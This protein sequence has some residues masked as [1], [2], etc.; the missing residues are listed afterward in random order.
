M[1]KEYR[2]KEHIGKNISTLDPKDYL[3][4]NFNDISRRELELRKGF[5][6]KIDMVYNK[7]LIY[8]T[9]LKSIEINNLF[10]IKNNRDSILIE[11]A[12]EFI[13]NSN[14]IEG[15]KI[16]AEEVKK[17][18]ENGDSKYRNRNEVKEVFNS[19]KA[20]EYIQNGFKFNISSIKG[21][22]YI[23]TQDLTMSNGGAYPKGFKKVENIV[24]NQPTVPSDQVEW[25]LEDLL[26]R[27][28]ENKK[29]EYPFIQAFDFHL[30][31]EYIHPFLDGNG[32]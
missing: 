23:L 1:G 9:E 30:R 32:R 6:D 16:P 31:Y 13:F 7:N 10:E 22:Y 20:F 2:I 18:I 26:N 14:N 27:Y 24:N 19:I 28:I 3:R 29:K 11:F 8:H 4:N 5:L 15:S 21:L 17:I 25:A 12:K